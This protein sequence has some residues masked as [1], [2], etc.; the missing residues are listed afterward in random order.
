M[1]GES[2]DM[3]TASIAVNTALTGHLL[4]STLHTNDAST[5]LPRL[6][7]MKIEPFLIA[8]TI[9]IAIGQRLIRKICVD[10][11]QEKVINEEEY[12]RLTKIIPKEILKKTK[13]FFVGGGCE[14]CNQTG[15]RGRTVINEVLL[16]DEK[17]RS[18]ILRKTPA[19]EIKEM[20][21][22]GGMSTMLS[23]GFK[24]AMLGITTIEEISRVIYE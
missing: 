15:Y 16:V 18:L 20:A 11:K 9:S 14:L 8:S 13:K 21:V 7:D 17:I 4:L 5:T 22:K 23:D 1:V 19:S 3:E 24:K 12:N 10:C 6:L 2:R